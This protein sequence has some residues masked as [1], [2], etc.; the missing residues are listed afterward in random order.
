[1]IQRKVNVQGKR[2]LYV[3]CI[4][5][6][7]CLILHTWSKIGERCTKWENRFINLLHGLEGCE[8]WNTQFHFT[9]IEIHG[10]DST[11]SMKLKFSRIGVKVVRILLSN[12]PGGILSHPVTL[13]RM[14]SSFPCSETNRRKKYIETIFSISLMNP[15]VRTTV[16][17]LPFIIFGKYPLY[18]KIT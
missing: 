17:K 12:P 2:K 1:M 8:H 15:F 16:N 3:A 9:R 18:K 7:R 10:E 11:S 4:D 13:I 6:Q 5:Y 14:T